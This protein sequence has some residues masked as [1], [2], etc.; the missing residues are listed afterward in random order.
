MKT[1]LH[2][3][4]PGNCREAFAFYAATF[5][6]KVLMT[7]T[8]GEAPPNAGVAAAGSDLILHTAMPLGGLTLMGCDS[9]PGQEQ[10]RS[11]FQV[12]VDAPDEAEVRRIFASLSE[13]GVVSIPLGPTFWSP[14][15]G[16]VRDR[17]GVPW[18]VGITG[19]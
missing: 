14:L 16:M 5:G 4:F 17:F 3:T 7:L 19:A 15:F 1:N 2:L 13:G 12:S 18:M 8:Y 9:L 10:A 11:G 6:S